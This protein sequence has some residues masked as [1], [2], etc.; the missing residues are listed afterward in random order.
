MARSQTLIFE[1]VQDDASDG[2]DDGQPEH[3]SGA[4]RDT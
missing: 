2:A 3:K 4:V 1:V